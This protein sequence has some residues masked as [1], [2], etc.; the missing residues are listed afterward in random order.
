MADFRARDSSFKCCFVECISSQYNKHD[1]ESLANNQLMMTLQFPSSPWQ[2]TSTYA[3]WSIWVCPTPPGFSWVQYRPKRNTHCLSLFSVGYGNDWYDYYSCAFL[4]LY[5][6]FHRWG[7]PSIIHFRFWLS[8]LNHPAIGVVLIPRAKLVKAGT[9][10]ELLAARLRVSGTKSRLEICGIF[11]DELQKCPAFPF[12]NLGIESN[13][14]ATRIC[15]T[16][17]DW[18]LYMVFEVSHQVRQ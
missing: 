7:Y 3:I 8:T 9:L 14:V 17:D 15:M 2:A 4:L 16:K 1:G 13:T 6:G 11:P 5:V 12:Q 10:S 18:Q